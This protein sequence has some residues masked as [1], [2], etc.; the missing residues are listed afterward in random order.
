MVTMDEILP[1]TAHHHST[2]VSCSLSCSVFYVVLGYKNV[3]DAST[4][5][6]EVLIS[7]QNG[8]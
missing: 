3:C 5:Q 4:G 1:L 8:V 6:Q 7:G 2:G